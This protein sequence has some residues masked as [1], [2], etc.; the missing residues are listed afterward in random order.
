VTRRARDAVVVFGNSG[1]D[2][3]VIHGYGTDCGPLL[4]TA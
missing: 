3:R 1:V 2:R 4:A